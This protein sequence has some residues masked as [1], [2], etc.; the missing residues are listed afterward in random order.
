MDLLQAALPRELLDLH[1]YA[2]VLGL[3][4][5]H[6]GLDRRNV[7]ELPEPD[8]GAV[9]RGDRTFDRLIEAPREDEHMLDRYSRMAREL[10][11][12]Y[13]PRMRV[14]ISEARW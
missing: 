14:R 8:G 6:H 13:E 1:S 10:N 5:V 4:P 12:D 3:E 7:P 9:V 11:A 2:R